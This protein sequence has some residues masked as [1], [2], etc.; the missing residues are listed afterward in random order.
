MPPLKRSFTIR[1]LD[2]EE[3]TTPVYYPMEENTILEL[4]P[5]THY[6][7]R[8]SMR[9]HEE[10][11]TCAK[12]IILTCFSSEEPLC[13]CIRPKRDEGRGSLDTPKDIII[14]IG[15]VVDHRLLDDRT[16]PQSYEEDTVTVSPRL[17][18]KETN[19]GPSVQ[20]HWRVQNETNGEPNEET[21]PRAPFPIRR[22]QLP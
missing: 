21:L 1:I 9:A 17:A 3:F 14:G 19:L 10:W 2:M 4:A 12:G 11:V 13:I 8:Y 18:S 5:T 15:I 7:I 6:E 20:L 16:A 22:W